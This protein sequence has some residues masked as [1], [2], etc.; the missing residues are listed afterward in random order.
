MLNLIRL[1]ERADYPPG[2]PDHGKAISGREAYR[3][4]GRAIAPHLAR[5]NSRQVWAAAPQ[6][7]VT[8]PQSRPGTSR[9]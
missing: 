4:Y 2:H 5:L 9:S 1:R 8:G 7:M 6:V 3:A